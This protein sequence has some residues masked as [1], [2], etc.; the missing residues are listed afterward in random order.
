MTIGELA[1]ASGV[2]ASTIRYWERIGLLSSPPRVRGRREYGPSA[3]H[4][5]A[6]LRFAQG[7]GFR[8]SEIDHLLRGFQPGVTASQRWEEMAQRKRRELRTQIARLNGMLDLLDGLRR[9]R[10]GHL[11]DCGGIFL[12]RRKVP[13]ARTEVCSER[14][15][16]PMG[17]DRRQNR[18]PIRCGART[19][20]DEPGGAG[21]F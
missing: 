16:L 13:M 21:G 3:V 8:L 1:S 5:I 2:H 20:E 7:C 9:C 10:C 15:D 11:R 12:N 4:S 6:V 18:D 17:R 14:R 19:D